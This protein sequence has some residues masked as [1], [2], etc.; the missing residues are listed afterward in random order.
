MGKIIPLHWTLTL[1]ILKTL[2]E[3]SCQVKMGIIFPIEIR[4]ELIRKT[5]NS[6]ILSNRSI[7]TQLLLHTYFCSRI[8]HSQ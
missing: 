8:Q 5:I 2:L 1:T 6:N 7:N 3:Q 4:P